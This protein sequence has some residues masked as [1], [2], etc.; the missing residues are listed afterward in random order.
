M[1]INRLST[2]L[3]ALAVAVSVGSPVMAAQLEEI[4]VTA[5]KKTESIQDVPVAVTAIAGQDIEQAFTLDTT[6]LQSFAPNVVFDTIEMGTPGG[7]GFSIRGISYQDVDKGFDPTVLVSV[8]DVP[9]ATGTGQVFDLIDI[10]RIEVLRGPQGTLFGKNVVGG[11]INIHRVKPVLDETSGKLRLRYGEYDKSQVDFLYNYG[12][13]NW[14]VK[15]TGGIARQGEGYIDNIAGGDLWYRDT[16]RFG[17]HLLWEPND[18]LTAEFIYDYSTLEGDPGTVFNTSAGE[19]SNI[20]G[21]DIFC[22]AGLTCS[23]QAGEPSTGSRDLGAIN[24]PQWNELD[25]DQFTV[26][27]TA[28]VTEDHT[29]TYVGSLMKA[30]DDQAIDGDGHTDTIYHFR[31]WGDFE[32]FTHELRLSRDSG[33]NLTW[34]VG[35]FN[36]YAEGTNN[37]TTLVFA[38]PLSQEFGRTTSD[39]YSFF[40]EADLALLDDKLV[41]TAGARYINETKKLARAA[42]NVAGDPSSINLGPN[43]GGSIDSSKNIYRLG[44]SYHFT[45]NV[46]GY[47]T[48]STGFRSGGLSPRAIDPEYLAQG[49]DPEEL[50]NHEIGLRTTLF[51]DTLILNLTAFDMEYEDMQIELAIAADRPPGTQ[52]FVVNAGSAT[53]Q[54][55]EL[56]FNW[57]ATDWWRIS[58]N[59]GTLDCEYDELNV[60]LYGFSS[61]TGAEYPARDESGLELRRCPELSYSLTST[62]DWEVAGG[63]VTWRTSYSW[64]DEYEATTTNYPNSGVEETGMLESSVS[65]DREKWQV[66]LYGRNLTDEDSWTHN[67]VVNA[68]REDIDG[69]GALWRFAQRRAP[70][71]IG[72]EL[73]YKF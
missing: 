44:A 17:A 30:D 34:Q 4:L 19:A 1:R 21:G 18:V 2:K 22:T 35:V 33:S 38:P 61:I 73:L 26:R 51:D 64:T 10:E 43:A 57:L 47:I 6:S 52:N 15:L 31:R 66:S 45:D 27:L 5:R 65:Y 70:R 37:Q 46:M 8:D 25:K 23:P 12:A 20:L 28:A 32:Q 13:D 40:G 60:N 54:G 49:Y 41:L 16:D 24:A 72:A 3:S 9:L 48:R 14:A 58:G 59:V 39:S 68:F 36:A 55:L 7:G 56:D 11:L 29:L 50:T 53:I 67:Y 62:M 63:I 42:Y 71:E 69:N